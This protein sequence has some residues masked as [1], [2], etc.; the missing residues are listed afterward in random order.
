MERIALIGSGYRGLFMYGTR[1]CSPAYEGRAQLCAIYD[2]NPVRAQYAADYLGGDIAVYD[3]YAR[4]LAE[5][6][7]DRVI[8]ASVDVMHGQNIIAALEAGI[9]VI[10]EKPLTT[11]RAEAEAILEA[12]RRTGRRVQVIFNMR[13]MALPIRVKQLLMEGAV[14]QVQQ[15]TLNW[16]LDQRH[17]ADYFRRWHAKLERSGG[18]LVHKASHHFDLVNWWLEDRVDRVS[19]AGDLTFYGPNREARGTRCRG[20]PHRASCEFYWDIEESPVYRGM[21]LEAEGEDGYVRDACVFRDEIDIYDTMS[22]VARYRGGA[23]LS[24][25]LN[26]YSPYE[27]WKLSITGD[28]GRIEVDEILSGYDPL[29][30]TTAVRV[31]HVAEHTDEGR[32]VDAETGLDARERGGEPAAARRVIETVYEVPRGTGSHGGGDDLILSE[33]VSG[34]AERPELGQLASTDDGV[35]ALLIGDLANESIRNGGQVSFAGR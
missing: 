9:D 3:D 18:L 14:G 29:P 32:E 4:L 11:T 2:P 25:S 15:V 6:R 8:V 1:L 17:G 5:A 13:Y 20:C 7:P 28:R 31:F 27:G 35:Q 21:Y 30:E 33:L 12:E 10:S 34:Q 26:A 23:Q 19:A 16:L 24:Y 22:V